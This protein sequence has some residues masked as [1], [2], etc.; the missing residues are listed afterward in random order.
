MHHS[1]QYW[2]LSELN[3]LIAPDKR[4]FIRKKWLIK[5]GATRRDHSRLSH[6]A[7]ERG[8]QTGLRCALLR[9]RSFGNL[10]DGITSVRLY[11]FRDG[12]GIRIGHLERSVRTFCRG[13][14]SSH[15]HRQIADA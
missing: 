9:G 6:R 5:E 12:G 11:H 2:Y 14:L 7:W 4:I 3:P 1:L 8:S 15:G 13:D 10:C